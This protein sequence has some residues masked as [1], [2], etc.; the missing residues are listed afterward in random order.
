MRKT[1]LDMTVLL[2]RKSREKNTFR[3]AASYLPSSKKSFIMAFIS[4]S[5][6]GWAGACCPSRVATLLERSCRAADR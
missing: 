6:E 1:V 4:E 5:P 2:C 3:V